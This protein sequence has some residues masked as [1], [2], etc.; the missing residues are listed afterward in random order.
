MRTIVLFCLLLGLGCG[1]A[2]DGPA[3]WDELP[4][5]DADHLVGPYA[6]RQIC[7]MCQ[8][9][10]DAGMLVFLRSD[11]A[12]A[13]ARRLST[14]LQAMTAEIADARFRSF[15]LVTGA[16][17]SAELLEILR[18]SGS[19]WHVAHLPATERAQAA[20][21]FSLALDQRSHALVFAQRRLLWRFDPES[22][23][24]SD[25]QALRAHSGYAMALLKSSYPVAVSAGGP[26][27]PKGLLWAAP[28]QLSA[29]IKIAAG[30]AMR[31]CLLDAAGKR[32]R[33]G[34]LVSLQLR[35]APARRHWARSDA[36]G[37]VEV[38]GLVVGQQILLE[39][40]QALQPAQTTRYTLTA[41]DRQDVQVTAR[42]VEVSAATITGAV[43][44]Q[45]RVVGLPCEGCT[46]VFD[47]LPQP[48]RTRARIAPANEP[49][50]SLQL[51][52]TVRDGSGAAR[53]GVVIYA[54]QTDRG[55]R[56]P[57]DRERTGAAANHGRLR[58]WAVSAADGSYAFDTI[59]PASYP[60]RR[61][62]QH[63]HM[64]V[65]EP[66]R[67][68]YYL[69]DVLFADDPY[70]KASHRARPHQLRGGSGVV[71]PQGSA[72][73]GWS[74]RRDISLGANVPG[75]AG[76]LGKS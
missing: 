68:T 50:E 11:V 19:S 46:L 67:C 20:R 52:G 59:R 3:I 26:D 62:P 48:L 53:A 33:A 42:D 39:L 13:D 57:P 24:S 22:I 44:G 2:D 27:T 66:G 12:P 37:C 51:S 16:K 25:L 40:Q 5:V 75:Y 35:E 49:G 28:A 45:E 74:A 61:E 76:C 15:V 65:I 43:T 72:A 4:A 9:G 36:E 6:G 70:L 38:Q 29:H 23:S 71:R 34:A 18:G 41:D 54:Y 60:F 58:G 7:P 69:G 64:H 73:A 47:G 30:A 1:R 63:I 21:D 31:V 10:Y 17:P 55:G 8:H 56:Y 14:L 32:P